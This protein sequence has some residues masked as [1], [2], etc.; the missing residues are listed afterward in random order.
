[1]VIKS[2]RFFF[3][4]AILAILLL[5]GAQILP[6][7]IGQAPGYLILNELVAANGAGLTD[8]DGDYSNWIEIY[9]Q[10]GQAVNLSGWS[11]TD[12]PNQPEKWTFPNVT[13][14]SHEYL[15][16]FASGKDRKPT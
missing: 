2:T 9:N 1:M 4:I 10:G 12:D 13:V 16:V 15:L 3:W 5:S 7:F 6:A 8:E 11:L 14:G